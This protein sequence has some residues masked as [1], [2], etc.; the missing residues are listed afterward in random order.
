[1]IDPYRSS[2]IQVV[3]K[4]RW[5]P[6]KAALLAIFRWFAAGT[7]RAWLSAEWLHFEWIELGPRRTMQHDVHLTRLQEFAD[8]LSQQ[9]DDEDLLIVKSS[10]DPLLMPWY[11]VRGCQRRVAKLAAARQRAWVT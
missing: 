5:N 4:K 1:M 11:Y 3:V 7:F 9:P 8:W 10:G 2:E 6:L